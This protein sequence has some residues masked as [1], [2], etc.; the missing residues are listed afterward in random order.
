MGGGAAL[1]DGAVPSVSAI[2]AAAI[3]VPTGATIEIASARLV[4]E[5]ST[6][7]VGD[8]GTS[9]Y[10][11]TVRPQWRTGNS[12]PISSDH[13]D[14]PGSSAG[15]TIRPGSIRGSC[16]SKGND[17]YQHRGDRTTR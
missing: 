10:R 16:T 15:R 4:A 12:T 13:D 1:H 11:P 3:R 8:A 5:K 17:W 14:T 6:P 7:V 2:I 9:T